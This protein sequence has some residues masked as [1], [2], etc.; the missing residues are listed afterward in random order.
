MAAEV[1]LSTPGPLGIIAGSGGLPRRVIESCR[2]SGREVFVLAL[3]G[4]ADRAALESVPHAWCRI[5]AAATALGLLRAN[6]FPD[7]PPRWVRA[8]LYRYRFTTADERR[9]TGAWWAR[10][11]A[12]PYFPE[13][14]LKP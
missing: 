12:G 8:Q 6:P 13:V 5:G 2:A 11:L 3:E 9:S 7:R 4:E 10:E 14:R 1:E